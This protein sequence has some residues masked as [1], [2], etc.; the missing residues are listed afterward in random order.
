MAKGKNNDKSIR[1][2]RGRKRGFM[3]VLLILLFAIG[4][5]FG[6]MHFNA[7]VTHLKY[8]EVYIEDLPTEFEGSRLL[9]VSDINI[10]NTSDISAVRHSFEKLQDIQ[11]DML[12]LGGDYSAETLISSL[13]GGDGTGKSEYAIEF[14]QSLRDFYAPLGKYAV[15]GENDSDELT[16]A[17]LNAGVRYLSDE[18]AVV[19]KGDAQLVIAGLSDG[20]TGRTP[21]EKIG[22][23]FNGNEC[24]IAVV[25]NPSAYVGIRVAEAK[26]GGAWADMVLSGHTLGGQIK[27]FNKTMRPLTEEEQRCISGWHY[28][29]DLPMLVS[30]GLG[31]KGA[32]LRLGTQSEIWCITLHK[33]VKQGLVLPEL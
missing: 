21:F 27:V 12:V 22:G 28:T 10:R 18:C 33:P 13:N 24:V 19:E 4:G 23:Y 31:C 14:I 9:F 15:S 11:A 30:Q 32:K 1:N 20:S 16:S 7:S 2:R 3:P 29:N 25:H 17:F 6:W 8:A 26:G 5:F